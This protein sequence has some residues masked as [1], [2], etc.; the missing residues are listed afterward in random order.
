MPT[1]EEW[2]FDT[3]I[4]AIQCVVTVLP[5]TLNYT[6]TAPLHQGASMSSVPL[7]RKG[8]NYYILLDPK[9]DG[10]VVEGIYRDYGSVV[11]QLPNNNLE[12]TRYRV[13]GWPTLEEARQH[14][15]DLCH[16]HHKCKLW[17]LEEARR[18]AAL[19]K[20]RLLM[21]ELSNLHPGIMSSVP[22]TLDGR[23]Q[24]NRPHTPSNSNNST[25][26][27]ASAN[28]VR[29]PPSTPSRTPSCGQRAMSVTPASP[30]SDD[31]PAYGSSEIN[32]DW[33]LYV[34]TRHGAR[35]IDG[36]RRAYRALQRELCRGQAALLL[37]LSEEAADQWFNP[38]E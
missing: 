22:V 5:T 4:D 14:W 20:P 10:S 8:N 24:F 12:G 15:K 33:Q 19:A 34:A 31:P 36:F 37:A 26:I 13:R 28:L 1:T 11:A 21:I 29:S 25:T 18:D 16:E 38:E 6:C 35:Q 9:Q 30:H 2:D 23:M 27:S 3:V 7:K 17:A 32:G